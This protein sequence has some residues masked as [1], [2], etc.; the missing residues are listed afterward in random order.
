MTGKYEKG[1][2][3]GVGV[4]PGD[5]ELITVKALRI[6]AY[7]DVVGIPGKEPSQ[8]V[9][10]RIAAAAYPEICGKEKLMLETPMTKDYNLLNRNYDELASHATARMLANRANV[11]SFCADNNMTTISTFPL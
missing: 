4:G 8:S 6:L 5:P 10:Y 3:F 9:A 2:L 7:C 11:W 1:L